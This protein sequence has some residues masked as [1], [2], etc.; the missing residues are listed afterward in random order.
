[1]RHVERLGLM[2][3]YPRIAERLAEIVAEVKARAP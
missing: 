1:V 2:T 3:H